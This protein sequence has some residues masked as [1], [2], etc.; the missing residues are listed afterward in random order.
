MSGALP[1]LSL[2]TLLSAARNHWLAGFVVMFLTLAL[3]VL[4]MIFLPRSYHSEAMIFVK[5]GRET[6][7]LD[8][9]ASTGSMVSVLESRDNEINSIRD[10]LYSRGI[11]EKVA[12]RI[13]PE[14]VLGD[15]P[16]TDES[17]ESNFVPGTDYKGSPR[18]K[19]ILELTENT[20]VINSRKSSVLTLTAESKSPELAQ[21]ILKEYLNV[22]LEM[23]NDAHQTPE[24]NQFFEEQSKLL[25]IQWQESMK[26]L[27]IAK[28]DAGVVSIEG[29]KENLKI[30]THETES[31]LM[32]LTGRLESTQ[33]K[34]KKFTDIINRNPL[35]Q[36]R[37]GGEY[38]A[39]KG[40]LSAM[41]AEKKALG[42]Q[43][44]GMLDK[45][46]KLNR[47]EVAI[48]G[49]EQE[50]QIAATNFAQ[51]QEL[52]EQTRIEAAL[53][54]D[55]FTNVR[56]VQEPSFVPK[57]VSPKKTLIGMA[58]IVA[59][60]SG[61]V[62]IAVFLELFM[63]PSRPEEEDDQLVPEPDYPDNDEF[64]VADTD[65]ELAGEVVAHGVADAAN[66]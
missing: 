20:E 39:A 32:S 27:Q 14:V 54:D 5:L 40:E 46:A 2:S 45:A 50:V 36:Q 41:L 58:G 60:T 35:D 26:A 48:G 63:T 3:A 16:L 31:T 29:A 25:K 30:Q 10:M 34:L 12:D 4:A 49:L 65:V 43:L 42:S 33:A 11:M 9:T 44:E 15:S 28:E 1:Q 37:I 64:T 7:S 62:L 53:H 66:G 47:D 22:Y 17:F 8:P 51:Y 59:G 24:S 61:A 56:I 52:H 38:L 57:P 6:V 55:R 21:R 19:A 13:G 18:Q 23:H